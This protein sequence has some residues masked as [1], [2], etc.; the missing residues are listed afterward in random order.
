M[1]QGKHLLEKVVELAGE[2]NEGNISLLNSL[3]KQRIVEEIT[4]IRP[5]QEDLREDR[6]I[7]RE[8]NYGDFSISSTYSLLVGLN[9]SPMDENWEKIWK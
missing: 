7:W 4:T 3:F 2:N 6:F 9:H 8:T 1:N 5:P